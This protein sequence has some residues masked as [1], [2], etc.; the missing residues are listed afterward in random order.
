MQAV[1][2]EWTEPLAYRGVFPG[3]ITAFQKDMAVRGRYGESAQ[4]VKRQ[5]K[6]IACADW[7]TNYCSCCQ[8]DIWG[9]ML[10]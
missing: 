4:F 9:S 3:R 2:S 10:A 1:L 6:R 5:V 7:E 8:M